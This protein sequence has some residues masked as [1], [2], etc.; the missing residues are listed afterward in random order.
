MDPKNPELTIVLPCLNE[1]E[2]LGAC[3]TEI[4]EMLR[5]ESIEAEVIGADN[6]STDRSIEIAREHGVIVMNVGERGYG[7]A[8]RGGIRAA[9]G[10]YVILGDADQSYNF[11]EVPLLLTKLRAGDDL[12]MGNR[13]LGRIE[14]GAMPWSHRRIGN[15]LLSKITRFL[16]HVPIHDVH[17]GLRGIRRAAYETL[18]LKTTGMEFASEMVVSA[19]HHKLTMSEVPVTLRRDGRTRRPHLRS[20][21]DGWR[22]LKFLI[23]FRRHQA[24]TR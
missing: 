24:Q 19:A 14:K 5:V 18:K 21:P 17:C 11:H 10:T 20:I 9:R 6:G 15:P 3:L 8:L 1:A 12:V 13:F 4:E 16:F 22:H 7:N 23:A 2:T